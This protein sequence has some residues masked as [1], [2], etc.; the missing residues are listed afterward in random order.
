MRR[1]SSYGPL[2]PKI[3]Y[4]APMKELIETGFTKLVG[5]SPGRGFGGDSGIGEKKHESL[6]ILR[7][8]Y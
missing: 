2:N 8:F 7:D 3:H 6:A 4:Y 1:F 5:E